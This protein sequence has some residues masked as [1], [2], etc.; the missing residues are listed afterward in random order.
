MTFSTGPGVLDPRNGTQRAGVVRG[1][2][3]ISRANS[4]RTSSRVLELDTTAENAILPIL[5]GR[6]PVPGMNAGFGNDGSD[7]IV[8]VVWCMGEVYEIEKVFLNGEDLPADTQV[9]HYRGSE[10]QGVD[11]DF[12]AIDT[13]LGYDETLVIQKPEGNQGICYSVFRFPAGSIPDGARFQAII[14]GKLVFD[15][16]QAFNAVIDPF[17][18]DVGFDFQFEGVNGSTPTT[19]QDSSTHGSSITWYGDANI[20]SNQADLDGATDYVDTEGASSF[21]QFG[22][23]PWSLEIKF[24]PQ[25]VSG[26][27]YIVSK[28]SS[29]SGNYGL[30]LYRTGDDLRV[31]MSNNGS[32]LNIF[33]AVTIASNVLVVGTEVDVLIEFTGREYIF[34]VDDSIVYRATD[35]DTVNDTTEPWRFGKYGTNTAVFEGTINVVRFT[36]KLR[37]GGRRSSTAIAGL[38]YADSQFNKQGYAY[39][40]DNP[41]LAFSDLAQSTLYGL[42]AVNVFNRLEAFNFSNDLIGGVPRTRIGLLIAEARPTQD[43]LDILAT[44]ADCLW[45]PEGDG[46]KLIPDR[47]I[48]DENPAGWSMVDNPDFSG[49]LDSWTYGSDYTYF[50]LFDNVAKLVGSV[51]SIEQ[52]CKIEFENGVEYVAKVVAGRTSG[53]GELELKLGGVPLISN[54]T[55]GTYTYL[56]TANGTENGLSLEILSDINWTGTISEITIS[57]KYWADKNIVEGSLT[58][59]NEEDTDTPTQIN[60]QY[61]KEVVDLPTWPSTS[62][63][64]KAPGVDDGLVPLIETNFNLEGVYR[65]EE[66]I[67]KAKARGLRL[68]NRY[69][70]SWVTTDLGVAL[71]RGT[72]TDVCDQ[73]YPF[74]DRVMVEGITTQS[75]GRYRVTG[76]RYSE[77]DYPEDT[78]TPV[79]AG[80][81]PVGV[82]ALLQGASVPSGWEVYNLGDG[83]LILG[84][85]NTIAPASSGGTVN[86]GPFTVTSN[87][88]DSDHTEPNDNFAFD[89]IDTG[90]GG[91]EKIL[92]SAAGAGINDGVELL[93][94][95]EPSGTHTH[96]L[97]IAAFDPNPV[98][99][100]WSLIQKITTSASVVPGN[101]A[102]MSIK[103]ISVPNL[104]KSIV[105]AGRLL[106]ADSTNPGNSGL[107]V[108]NLPSLTTELTDDSHAHITWQDVTNL[109]TLT[110]VIRNKT[111][112][113]PL[114]DGAG[115]AHSVT[116]GV[117]RSLK[118]KKLMLYT[119]T[120][121]FSITQG[122]VFM[123]AGSVA[124]IP[125]GW[126]LMD[127]LQGTI[128]LEDCFIEFTAA[129]DVTNEQLGGVSGGAS[130]GLRFSGTTSKIGHGHLQ[131]DIGITDDGVVIGSHL[132]DHRHQHDF[133]ADDCEGVWTPT[134]YALAFIMYN[135]NP[136][137]TWRDVGI[138]LF[139]GGSEGATTFTDSGPDSLT[140]STNGLVLGDTDVELTLNGVDYPTV[141]QGGNNRCVYNASLVYG[142]TFVVEG[143]FY[144]NSTSNGVLFGNG[145]GA[146]DFEV[147]Y[148]DGVGIEFYV[149]G[150]LQFT[151]ADPGTETWFY[152]AVVAD[153]D[154]WRFYAGKQSDGVATL[155]GT[156]LDTVA[157][158]DNGFYVGN[159]SSF[160][161][162]FEGRY[163]Q[164]R[165]TRNAANLSGT[166]VAI[167]TLPYEVEAP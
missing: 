19:G 82:I 102:V 149:D 110:T 86:A 18:A 119:G 70:V 55:T 65:S 3:P 112:Y 148:N 61:E 144:A 150:V 104:V 84:A 75:P 127:G 50:P 107:G 4:Y 126:S 12:A 96:D 95:E 15:I 118:R 105:G 16:T 85:G 97:T 166:G 152:V 46:V 21:K 153:E 17:L 125:S 129:D 87:A 134:Y 165:H 63:V 41:V 76:L 132:N 29:S 40:S 37:Y 23:D 62:T 164:V 57:R 56:F 77:S 141:E 81:V 34:H 52:D 68:A 113:A 6:K 161:D 9:T 35:T 66:A 51:Q 160:N 124:S 80:D 101:A 114:D 47:L 131:S 100:A 121:D 5:Y 7:L 42:G 143:F 8:R 135:P 53:S 147:R 10:W 163:C 139:D 103:D 120:D 49:N 27:D 138:M 28:S 22:S 111:I 24:T 99:Q 83:S 14:K 158:H 33:S 1:R 64:W 162:G 115:H 59:Q 79:D 136:E 145:S 43:W 90:V 26:T 146:E 11:E 123:W 157:S 159:N 67:N 98:Q 155:V 94:N 71:Q 106:S 74:E 72:I 31:S 48:T 20:Q 89:Q 137:P 88:G 154:N 30:V 122:M 151:A 73:S 93:T 133:I 32:S 130:H 2:L 58:I 91:V 117:T 128:D 13:I 142:D 39:S 38:P 92:F 44:Y 60:L 45:L 36:K 116:V 109:A 69:R 140:W 54:I 108:V 156:F 25:S 78:E 167:P